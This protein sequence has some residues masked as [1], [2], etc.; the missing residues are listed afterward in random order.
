MIVLFD[1][2]VVLDVL[3]DREPYS[4]IAARLI[5]RVERGELSGLIGA[6][7]LTTIHYLV[8]KVAGRDKAIMAV[9][10]VLMI[11]KVASVDR[12]VLELA[13][14][15]AFTDYEDAVL[16][17]AGRLAGAEAIVTRNPEDFASG[18]LLV[19]T[20]ADLEAIL[21]TSP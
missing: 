8:G 4:K 1:T 18:T 7:T 21:S 12:A 14:A 2:N 6:T 17:E 3:L 20:P 5:G 11:F 15:T 9:R 10:K 19:H 16:H 13:A